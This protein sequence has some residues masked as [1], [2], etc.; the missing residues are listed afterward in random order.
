MATRHYERVDVRLLESVG[1]NL[2]QVI[3]DRSNILEHMTKDGMLDEVY[4]E[5][6]GLDL[7][8]KYIAHMTAQIAHR[9]PRMNILEIGKITCHFHSVTVIF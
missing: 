2:P 4:E 5:G 7:V 8:N 3:R 6:F 9:Y 1:E